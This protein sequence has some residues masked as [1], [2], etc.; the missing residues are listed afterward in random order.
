V[1]GPSSGSRTGQLLVE[2]G[3]PAGGR[4][5]WPHSGAASNSTTAGDGGQRFCARSQA[6]S[7]CVL[8]ALLNSIVPL[9]PNYR[10]IAGVE[11]SVRVVGPQ[12][13]MAVAGLAGFA[14]GQCSP[15]LLLDG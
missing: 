5:G 8:G 1:G 4:E 14:S 2:G 9:L 15:A 6:T 7:R 10:R 13:A 3:H 11:E 12:R